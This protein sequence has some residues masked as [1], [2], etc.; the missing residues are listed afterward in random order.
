MWKP[1]SLG[2]K[3]RYG[4]A[5]GAIQKTARY[6][7]NPSSL[8]LCR[9][10]F[11]SAITKMS[12]PVAGQP[13]VLDSGVVDHGQGATQLIIEEPEGVVLNREH[14]KGTGPQ[15]FGKTGCTQELNFL[16][17]PQTLA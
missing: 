9:D 2:K 1:I 7:S 16:L 6:K 4:F 11:F 3:L 5:L 12:Q 10:Y 15:D 14:V 8:P 17:M 13:L